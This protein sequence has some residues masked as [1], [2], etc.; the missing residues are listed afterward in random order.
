M[1]Q[2]TLPRLKPLAVATAMACASLAMMPSASAEENSSP[3]ASSAEAVLP[4]VA[5]TASADAS[6]GGL[7]PAFTGGQVA[8]GARMGLLGNQDLMN[9]PFSANAYTSELIQDQQAKS[10]GDVLLN[11]PSVRVAR[12]FG[13]FQESYFIRGFILNS[14]SV[15]YNGL[16][17]L[18][19]RQYIAA[20]LFERVEVMRGA[21]AFL[22]GASPN[23]DGIGGTISLLPKRAPNE[24]LTRL[25]TGWS[26]GNQALF[27]A[28]IARRFGPGDSTGVRVNLSTR[29]GGTAVD[30][31]HTEL[32]LFSLGVD[33]RNDK[34]RLSA[35]VGY[36]DNKLRETRT[37]VTLSSTARSVPSAADSRSNWA[38]PWT[39]S[40]EKDLFGTLRGEYDFSES[41]TGWFAGGFRESK[42]ANS[43]ANLTVSNASTGAGTVY[44]FD[45]T[46]ED[47]VRTGEIGLRGKF[48]T[49]SVGHQWVLSSSYFDSSKKNAYVM[50]WQNTRATNL[51]NP[52][53]TT[54]PAF[55][56]SAL[57]GNDLA[58][59]A[60]QGTVTMSSQAI[61][62]TLS[63][64]DDR[65]LVTAGLRHQKFD[66]V[67]Y[68]Y[69]TG[70]VSSAYQ[71]SRNS[72]M[73]GV[74]VKPLSAVKELSVYTNYIE[75]L[76]QGGTA[77]SSAANR[78]EMLSPY[79]SKQ[80]E[81]GVKGDFGS[82][83]F[84]TAYFN[85]EKPRAITNSA[86]YYTAEGRDEHQGLEF[87]AYGEAAKGLRVLGGVT[88]IDARQRHTNSKTTDGKRAIG[89]PSRQAN[90]GFDWRVPGAGGLSFDAR[91][92]AT[93][94][95]YADNA[96]TLLVPGWTRLDFGARYVTELAG[97]MVTLRARV[98]N[99]TD[100]AYWA[101]SGGYPDNGYLV[102]GAPRTFTLSASVD[103]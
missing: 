31:E 27:S 97:K 19:P 92:I 64:F 16:Y 9:T 20:E 42:E 18:L 51:Y 14:D 89:V 84:T 3:T 61:G 55:S 41:L 90:L 99:V 66:V 62:D 87:M 45:N 53:Y 59:P 102:L 81:I 82:L 95:V 72:P 103:L 77:P 74:V 22:N 52:G 38:Q 73:L 29:N 65:V 67:S 37:N 57:R 17:G 28:D 86:G 6:A 50:D 11:D 47:S 26:S 80:K 48:A 24:P 21:S 78:G 98:D 68:A 79:V 15:A 34:A 83:G 10:V 30:R 36:Q 35:D 49:G 4:T 5:V 39:Y 69:N 43:L 93:G 60:L 101:S 96:N 75:G 100:R 8:R 44:R 23:S 76:S 54:Q 32:G 70:A 88:L 91:V 85:T 56:A 94:S 40:N 7:L 1:M 63:M 46:R 25:T 13:N 58:N 2:V 12:G 71:M 33:W